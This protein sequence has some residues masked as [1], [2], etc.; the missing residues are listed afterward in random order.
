[1]TTTQIE[2]AARQDYLKAIFHLGRSSRPVL[3]S[4]LAESLGVRKPSVSAMLKRLAQEGLIHYS[5]RQGATLSAAGRA[6]SLR[7]VRR[8]R[9]LETFLVRILGLDWSEVHV[10]AE[11]LEHHLS[12]RIV[13]AIDRALGYPREDPHGHPIPDAEGEL[14]LRDIVPLAELAL[15]RRAFVR[16]VRASEPGRL[17]RWKQMGLVPGA[18]VVMRAR[19]AFEDVM[20][21]VVGGR[22]V[23]TGSEGV[24]GVFVEYAS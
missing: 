13:A 12:E 21:L 8:H 5:P 3:T 4:E 10:E 7:V 15:G 9:L 18:E 1:V 19:Q 16:E 20:H 17:T 11:V 6:A 23:V 24:D 22:E 2:T 14:H